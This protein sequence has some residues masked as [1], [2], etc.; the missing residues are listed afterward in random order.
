MVQGYN[1][2]VVPRDPAFRPTP[3]QVTSVV[4]YL[5]ERLE[6]AEREFSVDGEDELSQKDAIDHLRAAAL[7]PTGGSECLVGFDD[8]VC[9]EIF[10]YDRESP[11]PDE[12]FWAD[13]LKLQLNAAPFPY[14]DW[15]YEDAYCAKCGARI[16]QISDLLEDL[17]LSGQPL[18][19][20]CGARTPPAELRMT[21]GVRLAQF[22]IAFMGNRGWFHEV[23]DDREAFKDDNFLPMIEEL[24][25]T[26]VEVIAVST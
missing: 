10:G 24:L 2:I 21:S 7:S 19:C 6:L 5:V 25:G 13:E 16:E 23:E 18:A 26:D 22:A 20:P 17:R 15:D 12:N 1:L 14:G 8:L 4:K 11:D 3:D 9:G